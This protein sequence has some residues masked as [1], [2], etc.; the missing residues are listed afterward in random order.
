MYNKIL[1][2]GAAGFMGSHLC[3]YLCN[4]NDVIGVDDFSCGFK[5]NLSGNYEFEKVDL[6]NFEA[7]NLLIKKFK[8]DLVY[9]LA[10]W[11]H[12]GLSQFCPKLI[13]E[14]NYNAYLNVLTACVKY[15]VQKIVCCSSMSVY[16]NQES[17][18]TEDMNRKP[19]DV[20]AIAKVA[21]EQLTEIFSVVYGIKYCIC[22]P[23]NCYGPRQNMSDPYR[24]VIAIFINRLLQ[25]KNFFIYGDGNQ[26]R[27]FSYIDDVIPYLAKT[28]LLEECN[29][30]IINLGPKEE[31]TINELADLLLQLFDKNEFKPKYLPQRPQEVKN[32]WCDSKKAE[33][34]LKYRTST[35]LKEGLIKM[36]EWAKGIGFSEPKYLD[37]LEIEK[38]DVP[39]TWKNKLI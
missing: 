8:P 10:A 32:A 23:H 21:M 4:N 1:I 30:H 5:H 34:L 29:S 20:Y 26:K 14:N 28:G 38:G 16:G 33:D 22:R 31:T 11:A 37:S 35:T 39:L 13:T 25:N 19:D 3:D 9:H 36:I 15:D 2:T 17:P 27:S 18:F 6:K 7:I 24:N 12:E